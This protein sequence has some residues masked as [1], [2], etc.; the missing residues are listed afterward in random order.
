MGSTTGRAP[1]DQPDHGQP[2]R[3]HG[4]GYGPGLT[5]LEIGANVGSFGLWALRRRQGSTVHAGIEPLH[6][7]NGHGRQRKTAIG[8]VAGQGSAVGQPRD[9][10]RES[11]VDGD[12]DVAKGKSAMF[13][14]GHSKPSEV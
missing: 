1:S 3:L 6:H 11:V 7:K 8:A 4:P 12:D 5:I 9:A 13:M 2:R 10:D 14:C